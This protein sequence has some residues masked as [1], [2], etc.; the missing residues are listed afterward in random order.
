MKRNRLE[1]DDD[2]SSSNVAVKR[3]PEITINELAL[4]LR[5]DDFDIERNYH[6]KIDKE[7][8]SIYKEA[9]EHYIKTFM[10]VLGYYIYKPFYP[11]LKITSLP[12]RRYKSDLISLDYENEPTFWGNCL[13]RDYAK[14]EYICRHTNVEKVVFF[15]ITDDTTSLIEVLRSKIHYKYH[16]IIEIVNFFPEIIH[17]I[18]PEEVVVIDDWFTM[19]NLQKY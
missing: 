6:F 4:E 15:E 7:S 12:Y 13:E 5:E 2:D 10:R 14:I 19:I 16:N 11:N 18:D 3:K 9:Q 17:Y 8:I 1:E